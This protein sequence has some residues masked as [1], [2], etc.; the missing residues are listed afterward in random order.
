MTDDE[1]DGLAHLVKHLEWEEIRAQSP[2]GEY[3]T[4]RIGGEWRVYLNLSTGRVNG[5]MVVAEGEEETFEAAGEAA[6]AAAQA[7]YTRRILSALNL[8]ALRS[9]PADVGQS[10]A[11][12]AR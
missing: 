7:D 12:N 10:L 6:K 4:G 11:R 1:L 2:F 9:P 8:D 3:A 5:H